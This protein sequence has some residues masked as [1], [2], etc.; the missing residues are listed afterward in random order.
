V[1][2]PYNHKNKADKILTEFDDICKKLEVRYVLIAGTCLGF[3]R[4]GGYITGDNDID[5]MLVDFAQTQRLFA[6]LKNHGFQPELRYAT[7]QHFFKYDVLI[8]VFY[9]PRDQQQ[10]NI[11]P[12][13]EELDAVTYGNR[14]YSLPGPVED[15]LRFKYGEKWR[16][17]LRGR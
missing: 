13:L 5:V 17:P 7:N 1:L 6:A 15:Y 14:E 2:P 12:F 8:D 16:I 3:Y 11:K 10:K 4:D 9:R